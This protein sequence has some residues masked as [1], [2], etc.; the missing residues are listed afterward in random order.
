MADKVIFHTASGAE[1]AACKYSDDLRNLDLKAD[2]T[3]NVTFYTHLESSDFVTLME[4]TELGICFD[5]NS[6]DPVPC[7]FK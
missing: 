2:Q 4:F 5:P 3:I 7:S 1:R 6:G